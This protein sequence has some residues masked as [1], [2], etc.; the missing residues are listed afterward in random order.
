MALSEYRTRAGAIIRE[1]S[2]HPELCEFIDGT[3]PAPEPFGPTRDARLVILGQDPT[4]KRPESRARVRVVLNLD[5]GGALRTYLREVCDIFALDLDSEVAAFNVANNFFTAPPTQL[6]DGVL[7]T[8][9]DRWMPVVRDQLGCHPH[10]CVMS[11]GEPVL[12]LLAREDASRRVREYWGYINAK[13]AGDPA[14]FRALPGSKSR[15][16]RDIYPFPHQPSRGRRFYK[17]TLP[18]YARFVAQRSGLAA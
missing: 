9:V 14:R 3:L 4:V 2:S 18:E 1:L 10:A 12:E 17:L 5:R 8:A 7:L 16:A 11:L 15:F 13:V 6:P